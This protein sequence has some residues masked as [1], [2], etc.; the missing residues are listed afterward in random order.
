MFAAF[1]HTQCESPGP[2]RDDAG[3]KIKSAARFSPDGVD[4]SLHDSALIEER[5][6][7]AVGTLPVY[8]PPEI[9][10][11][12]SNEEFLALR[13]TWHYLEIP[14]PTTNG[15]PEPQHFVFCRQ[16][17][18]G[19]AGGRPKNP[20]HQGFVIGLADISMVEALAQEL[21]EFPEARPADFA[22]W[23]DWLN[24]R[25]DNELE[26]AQLEQDN[27]PLPGLSVDRRRALLETL[28]DVDEAITLHN[29]SQA[30]LAI[31]KG[32]S[33][34]I[35]ADDEMDFLLWVSLVTHL[36]PSRLAWSIPFSTD[37]KTF[38]GSKSTR[39]ANLVKVELG[40][41]SAKSADSASQSWARL[42]YSVA[43]SG[44]LEQVEALV[45]TL[46]DGS[47]TSGIPPTQWAPLAISRLTVDL[48][49]DETHDSLLDELANYWT[50]IDLSKVGDALG[51]AARNMLQMSLDDPNSLLGRSGSRASWIAALNA[52]DSAGVVRRKQSWWV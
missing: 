36:L 13:R 46:A 26:V 47:S 4:L 27:P 2:F 14:T 17:T 5:L 10:P 51:D 34:G 33:A 42:V 31:S 39:K 1:I 8:T 12:I 6:E 25:G 22:W 37:H 15:E 7:R 45:A 18:S 9:G 44:M 28:V 29:L 19:D 32:Q 11:F 3:Y 43:N 23:H 49:D 24:P 21:A 30:A 35:R 38:A 52:N 16:F 20:F 40:D 48:M 50:Q 41:D